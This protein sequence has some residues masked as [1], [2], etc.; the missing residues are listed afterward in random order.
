MGNT[1]LV[2]SCGHVTDEL[3][4]GVEA[5]KLRVVLQERSDPTAREDALFV[6]IEKS[7]PAHLRNETEKRKG[8][9]D[10]RT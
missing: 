6:P 2:K 10:S 5:E 4:D 7:A 3:E 9:H 1:Y 8:S